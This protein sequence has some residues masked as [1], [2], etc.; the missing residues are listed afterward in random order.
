MGTPSVRVADIPSAEVEVV[1]LNGRPS[2]GCGYS[3]PVIRHKPTDLHTLLGRVNS[4][5]LWD[6]KQT[7]DEFEQLARLTRLETPIP[8]PFDNLADCYED[9]SA[10][11]VV[12]WA[13]PHF[14]TMIHDPKTDVWKTALN[15]MHNDRLLQTARVAV[16]PTARQSVSAY[17]WL[18]DAGDEDGSGALVGLFNDWA[19]QLIRRYDAGLTGD[20][21]WDDL[22]RIADYG[23]S[24]AR[25]SGVRY[26]L[27]ARYCAA[28]YYSP[29]GLPERAHN[30]FRVFVK[31]EFK[32]VTWD[33]F[34]EDMRVVVMRG[35]DVAAYRNGT[36]APAEAS[37]PQGADVPAS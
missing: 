23:L 13:T 33:R 31:N 10:L 36:P 35:K 5:L 18:A 26:L 19:G 4:P 14:L 8:I 17:F 9:E 22:K 6:S 28:M 3:L 37:V 21:K 30:V 16:D 32:S 20:P 1:G 12:A 2:G 7:I 25:E 29:D 24:A 11:P 27:Y 34:R 15:V